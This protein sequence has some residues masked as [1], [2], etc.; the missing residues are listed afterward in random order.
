[1]WLVFDK[2]ITFLPLSSSISSSTC[3]RV[4]VVASSWCQRIKRKETEIVWKM[5]KLWHCL[6]CKV[7]SSLP[8]VLI[9][10]CM[11]AV[12]ESGL[13]KCIFTLESCSVQMGER[14]VMAPKSFYLCAGR[15][16]LMCYWPI[17]LSPPFQ[18]WPQET[19]L[20]HSV[21]VAFDRST[22]QLWVLS[23]LSK[24]P[25][26]S[27]RSQW[28][29]GLTACLIVVFSWL[30]LNY[31]KFC[32]LTSFQEQPGHV[33]SVWSQTLFF[34]NESTTIYWWIK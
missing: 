23:N 28:H 30:N 3:L 24:Y 19:A 31:I 26:A 2:W 9:I 5:L 13:R 32:T 18:I 7:V 6:V 27:F 16:E 33:V 12:Q 14:C 11:A 25:L 8:S 10:I 21:Q 22:L 20:C 17:A 15:R 29:S 4:S 1:M 34:A